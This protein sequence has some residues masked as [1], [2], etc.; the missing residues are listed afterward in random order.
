MFNNNFFSSSSPFLC[1]SDVR[2][3]GEINKIPQCVNEYNYAQQ[4]GDDRKIDR[5]MCICVRAEGTCWMTATLAIDG[6]R[7][8][9]EWNKTFNNAP[10][11][12]QNV[13]NDHR[14]RFTSASLTITTQS[15]TCT[16]SCYDTDA[17]PF[18]FCFTLTVRLR[19]RL[20]NG[21]GNRTGNTNAYMHTS[22]RY[23]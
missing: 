13:A 14:L 16:R 3:E 20:I 5:F 10:I 1:L 11:A 17:F 22:K 8:K 12:R 19:T 9:K 6:Q 7:Y 23:K 2:T 21:K 4:K 18:V 15:N